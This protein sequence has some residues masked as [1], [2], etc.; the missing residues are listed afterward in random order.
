[1][2]PTQEENHPTE[3]TQQTL[4]DWLE[5][6]PPEVETRHRRHTDVSQDPRYERATT[7]G[8]SECTEAPTRIPD[9]ILPLET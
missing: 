2:T 8:D 7:A 4:N 6:L 3:G 5:P 1:M 9:W